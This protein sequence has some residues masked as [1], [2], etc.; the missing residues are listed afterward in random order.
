[1]LGGKKIKD[2]KEVREAPPRRVGTFTLGV[3][4]VAAGGGMLAAMFWPQADVRWMLSA[5]PVI[6]ILLGIETLLAARGGGRVKY[7]WLGM[8]LCF[9]LVGAALSMY[10]AAW[11]F[12]NGEYFNASNCSR[13]ADE[14]SY[15]M[16]YGWFDGFDSHTFRLEAGDALESHVSTH[17][18]SLAVEIRDED[19][20]FLL[21]ETLFNEVRTTVIPKDGDYTVL[22]HG[23]QVSGSFSFLVSRGGAENVLPPE[24]PEPPEETEDPE[25][26]APPENGGEPAA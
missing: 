26:E 17:R 24:D 20:E 14:T 15:R 13:Y 23:Q 6:L 12:A 21:K 1:M 10:A 11:Y 2:L 16:D 7:D 22:A 4:L 25:A 5:S 18:G 3:V 9:I 19:G 8:F